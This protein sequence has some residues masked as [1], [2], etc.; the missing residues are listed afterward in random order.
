MSAGPFR[1][2]VGDNALGHHFASLSKS[3]LPSAKAMVKAAKPAKAK[4]WVAKLVKTASP[5][6]AKVAPVRVKPKAK[7]NA[8]GRGLFARLMGMPPAPAYPVGTTFA[9]MMGLPRST[10]QGL[11]L[12]AKFKIHR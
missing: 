7:P 9:E 2:L 1:L 3:R 12:A 4:T 11:I 5:V 6:K 8:D 10:G